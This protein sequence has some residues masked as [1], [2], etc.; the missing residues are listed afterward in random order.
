MRP[1]PTRRWQVRAGRSRPPSCVPC[2]SITL[3]SAPWNHTRGGACGSCTCAV[4]SFERT[5][6][7]LRQV[8]GGQPHAALQDGLKVGLIANA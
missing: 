5:P 3:R 6:L 2:S 7:L 8:A 4:G 1:N